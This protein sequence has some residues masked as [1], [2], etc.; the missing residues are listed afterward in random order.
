MS[1]IIRPG[2]SQT[3]VSSRHAGEE[4]EVLEM[5]ERR[6]EGEKEIIYNP[7][8]HVDHTYREN[9]TYVT[10]TIMSSSNLFSQGMVIASSR[11]GH[12]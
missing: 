3:D 2:S 10:F 1:C 7:H 8:V 9:M 12:G 5:G 11:M 6:R 4:E